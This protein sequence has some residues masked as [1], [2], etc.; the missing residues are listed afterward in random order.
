VGLEAL[1]ERR[2]LPT[3]LPL[4]ILLTNVEVDT[5]CKDL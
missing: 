2:M 5:H 1:K 4:P 3:K